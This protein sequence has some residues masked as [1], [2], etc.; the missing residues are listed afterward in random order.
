MPLHL[1][2]TCRTD[3]KRTTSGFL[4]PGLALVF[5]VAGG[6]AARA[7][8]TG[9]DPPPDIT[10]LVL[11]VGP[12]S[13]GA[14]AAGPAP[15]VNW[16]ITSVGTGPVV[17]PDTILL[18]FGARRVGG[19]GSTNQAA[20]TA[21]P[22]GASTGLT[23]SYFDLCGN[24]TIPWTDISFTCAGPIPG[25]GYTPYTCGPTSLSSGS[26]TVGSMGGIPANSTVKWTGTILTFTLANGSTYTAGNYTGQMIFTVS[27]Q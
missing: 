27:F 18:E 8:H 25:A 21:T 24:A 19:G 4:W 5:M 1:F 13:A 3:R 15:V 22:A 11:I 7:D 2:T 10:S 23:C 9:I 6:Q 14:G 20:V 16:N 17:S 26:T 12:A